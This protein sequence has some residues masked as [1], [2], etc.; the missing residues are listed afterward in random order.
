MSEHFTDDKISNEGKRAQEIS[1]RQ[2]S[3]RAGSMSA[4]FPR[5]T[6]TRRTA[7]FNALSGTAAGMRAA[8]GAIQQG[9]PIS[10]ALLAAG[11]ALQAPT[12]EQVVMAREAQIAEDTL[13]QLEVAPLRGISPQMVKE[14]SDLGISGAEDLPLGAIRTLSPL[15]EAGMAKRKQEIAEFQAFLEQKEKQRQTGLGIEEGLRKELIGLSKDFRTIRD[16]YAR[17]EASA[18]DP[19]AAGDL[20]LIFNY[21]KILDPGS[22]VRES[23]F[24][25]AQNSAGVPEIV[26]ARYNAVLRGERLSDVTRADFLSRAQDLY[27]AQSGINAQLEKQYRRLAESAGVSPENVTF[28]QDLPRDREAV[29]A[30]GLSLDAIRA[31]KAR[32]QGAR[33]Q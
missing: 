2:S 10:A 8:Q 24:A 13:K 27:A 9:D 23:E 3:E 7:F 4:R 28:S 29:G 17:V 6:K 16:S 18:K 22:V 1:N 5:Y 19:S 32:R 20:A 14:L 31:E 11:G 33:S 26:R 12:E 30:F 25:N 21:M 15:I